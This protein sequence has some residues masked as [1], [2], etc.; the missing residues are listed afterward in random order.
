[1]NVTFKL[2][3]H[4]NEEENSIQGNGFGQFAIHAL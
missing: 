3:T 1:M 2:F 4:G